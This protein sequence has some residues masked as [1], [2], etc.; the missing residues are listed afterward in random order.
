MKT[1]IFIRSYPKD[2]QWLRYCLHS[3][4]KFCSGF[5]EVVIAIPE[6]SE[7]P[8][9]LERVV[10]IPDIQPG[11]LAQQSSKVH[12]DILTGA[13]QIS[14]VDSD[15]VFTTPVTPETFMTDGR[16]NW[17]YTPWDEVGDDAR[18]AWGPVMEKCIGKVSPAEWM[19]RHPQL[20][21]AWALQ[22]F[23]G[24]IMERHGMT[25]EDYIMSQLPGRFSEFN[26][27]GFYLWEHHRDKINWQ[28]TDDGVPPAVLDQHW[29]HGGMTPEIREKIQTV[30]A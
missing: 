19:R 24:F 6:G 30:L 20:I 28:N 11:Y 9:T 16:P 29:S 23:R 4:H 3:I 15:C 25:A 21:P 1:S 27:I 12:A 14:F 13:D 2:F 10:H 7:F 5:D 22:E 8:A 26:C 17:L 18:H